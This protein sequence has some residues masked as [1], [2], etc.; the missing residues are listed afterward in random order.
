[1]GPANVWGGPLIRPNAAAPTW[2]VNSIQD[3]PWLLTS[4]PNAANLKAPI[5][6]AWCLIHNFL[7]SRLPRELENPMTVQDMRSSAKSL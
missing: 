3:H 5:L 1:M 4:P 6:D 7:R 2:A